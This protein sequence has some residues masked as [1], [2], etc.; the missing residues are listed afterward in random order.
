[1]R[2]EYEFW[3]VFAPFV[4]RG[5]GGWSIHEVTQ[6]CAVS[7]AAAVGVTA[8]LAAADGG[9]VPL[10]W[11]Q[12]VHVARYPSRMRELNFIH[13]TDHDEVYFNDI[14]NFRA[15]RRRDPTRHG[16][17]VVGRCALNPADPHPPR[18]IG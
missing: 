7:K 10:R 18:M 17:P 1:M 6:L 15:V 9:P 16:A 5:G 13:L 14:G 2:N 12:G 3:S 4:V 8:A 11:N